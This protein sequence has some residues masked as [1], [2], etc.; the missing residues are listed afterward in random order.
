MLVIL[1]LKSKVEESQNGQLHLGNKSI[2]PE[3][4]HQKQSHKEDSQRG[5]NTTDLTSEMETWYL[6]DLI[7][8]IIFIGSP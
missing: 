1:S 2:V 5:K 3:S 7:L 4:Q 6:T 8:N